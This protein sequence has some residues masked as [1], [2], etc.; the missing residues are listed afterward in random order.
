MHDIIIDDMSSVR[1]KRVELVNFI[2]IRNGLDCNHLEIDFD[3][4]E[5][6]KIIIIIGENGT[7]KSTFASVL[8]ALPYATD[9]RKK[10]II[11]GKEGMKKLIYEK[12]DGTL[13][14][15]ILLWHPTKNTHTCK[16][17]I[18]IIDKDGNLIEALNENGN[19]TSY[20]DAVDRHLHL[21][22]QILDLA[23]Q[24]DVCR[25]II[26]KTS[27][28]RKNSMSSFLPDNVYINYYKIANERS[29]SVR[30]KIDHL[31]K[32]TNNLNEKIIV[33]SIE[34]LKK[35]IK[36][37][38][39]EK[40]AL[41][42]KSGQLKGKIT[43][44]EDDEDIKSQEKEL[45]SS[46]KDVNKQLGKLLKNLTILYESKLLTVISSDS[47]LKNINKAYI[48]YNDKATMYRTNIPA[49]EQKIDTLKGK[50]QEIK[51]SLSKN[52]EIL[53]DIGTNMSLSELR[54]LE[55]DYIDRSNYI[56]PL[57]N[58]LKSDITISD[59]ETGYSIVSTIRKYID[60]LFDI[61]CEYETIFT[62]YSN[63]RDIEN[64]INKLV[65]IQSKIEYDIEICN[66]RIS[67]YNLYRTSSDSLSKRPNN[68][69]SDDC[70]FIRDAIK[71]NEIK[72]RL[73]E[74]VNKL[75]SLTNK[76]NEITTN[77]NELNT[78][79]SVFDTLEILFDYINGNINV[80]KKL[81][82]SKVYSSKDSIFKILSKRDT[83]ELAKCDKFDEFIEL[84]EMRDEYNDIINNKLP[85]IQREIKSL[86]T[87]GS[88][89][90]Y[91]RNEIKRLELSYRDLGNE[92]EMEYDNLKD[93][94]FELET[95]ESI[96][97]ALTEYKSD[98]EDYENLSKELEECQN[99]LSVV[100]DKLL[101][102]SNLKSNLHDIESDIHRI[103]KIIIPKEKEYMNLIGVH[104]S[105]IKDMKDLSY[106][107]V[108]RETIDLIKEALSIK[109]GIPMEMIDYFVISIKES[110]N[111]ILDNVY[112]GA[113]RLDDFI[114]DEK[115]FIIPVSKN[116]E[117]PVD[118]QN[119]SS[120][121]RSFISLALTM[122]IIEKVVNKYGI[123]TLDELDRGFSSKTKRSFISILNKE[124]R[125]I[126]L[127]QLFMVS[128]NQAFYGGEDV[129]YLVFPNAD[130]TNVE[131]DN[132]IFIDDCI[133][134]LSH[135]ALEKKIKR[136]KNND[137][138][139]KPAS[140]LN[141]NI[142][143]IRRRKK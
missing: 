28:D 5:D 96:C 44:L 37:L 62:K 21:N 104:N 81:P 15:C 122:A 60:K 131:M 93:M 137:D 120:S 6:K 61:N 43:I 50:R 1:I 108:E 2:G 75:S 92:I 90:E 80:I 58:K 16:G 59:F 35:D 109:S 31:Q 106:Y 42:Q 13:Y 32:N 111:D 64:E 73:Q 18:N 135:K 51:Q 91:I 142:I 41:I 45:N 3:K 22:K 4:I 69:T 23:N 79:C 83:S 105:Y 136:I 132:C 74:D 8:H 19:I 26:D 49:L 48:F 34:E 114:I 20:E 118:V 36:R 39:D 25:G 85:N 103:D 130:L 55:K 66:K 29:I 141:P 70:P 100:R 14:E 95:S 47:G 87:Q 126:G 63:K 17:Y 116:G 121:E 143:I 140:D 40:E 12:N 139:N 33:S 27:T 53:D 86:E 125:D 129:A 84:V 138:S 124:I 68:C 82:Y 56:K 72:P 46:I 133:N 71:W 77:I 101:D 67:D 113:I 102:L 128:H 89:I 11:K 57:I 30:S 98:M 54:E 76:L 97:E 9:G 115:D 107:R 112:D 134:N 7:G 110:A 127:N 38:N 10:L 78:L 52:R 123:C 65:A 88:Y 94:K 119:A 24:N 99:K 117:L